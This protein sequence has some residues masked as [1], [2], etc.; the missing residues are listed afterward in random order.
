MTGR[1]FVVTCLAAA[2]SSAAPAIAETDSATGFALTLPAGL[3]LRT[4]AKGASD[5][6]W[7]LLS[8]SGKPVAANKDGTLCKLTCKALPGNAGL[9]RQRINAVVADPKRLAAIRTNMGQ[10]FDVLDISVIQH[11]GFNGYR[12]KMTP[13]IGPDAENVR[14]MLWIIETNKGRASISC[15]TKAPDWDAAQKLFEAVR[16]NMTIPG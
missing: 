12:M 16:S 6:A 3:T 1:A 5:V 10:N 9:T 7:S 8:P 14:S 13:R 11:Q 4:S 15:A 2:L